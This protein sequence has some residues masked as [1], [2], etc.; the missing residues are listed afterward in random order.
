[1]QEWK[2]EWVKENKAGSIGL[3]KFCIFDECISW[4][5]DNIFDESLATREGIKMQTL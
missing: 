2:L 5:G 4:K 1:M 3:L